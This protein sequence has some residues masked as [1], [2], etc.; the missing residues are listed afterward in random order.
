M[1]TREIVFDLLHRISKPDRDI[2]D[3]IVAE[4]IK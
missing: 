1:N 3:L 4:V 2:L